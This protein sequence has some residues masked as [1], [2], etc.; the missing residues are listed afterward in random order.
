MRSTITKKHT[1][2]QKRYLMTIITAGIVTVMLV[3]V[4]AFQYGTLLSSAHNSRQ[5]EPVNYK[6]YKSIQIEQGDSFWNIAEEYMSDEYD[7][8]YDYM[9]ELMV[10]NQ[11]NTSEI[12]NLQEGDYLTVVYY[13][14]ELK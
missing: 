1:R 9:E 4:L 3:L 2:S 11:L 14:T 7:S 10:V 6:Y 13:D 5:E 12:D 8:I